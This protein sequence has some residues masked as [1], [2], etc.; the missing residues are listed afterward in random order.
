MKSNKLAF[1]ELAIDKLSTDKNSDEFDVLYRQKREERQEPK[2]ADQEENLDTDTE[3][4]RDDV[5]AAETESEEDPDEVVSTESFKEPHRVIQQTYLSVEESFID[6]VTHH[7]KNAARYVGSKTV[8]YGPV[9]LRNVY[10]GVKVAINSTLK[11]LK[12]LTAK[13]YKVY[14]QHINSYKNLHAKLDDIKKTIHEAIEND[15]EL[16]QDAVFSN[17]KALSAFTINGDAD[18]EKAISVLLKFNRDYATELKR[19][20]SAQI[21]TL[22]T[23]MESVTVEDN[24]TKINLA[25]TLPPFRLSGFS[26][27]KVRGYNSDNP[28]LSTFKYNQILPGNMLFL[29]YLPEHSLS[30]TDVITVC[31]ESNLFLGFDESSEVLEQLPIAEPKDLLRLINVAQSLCTV[32]QESITTY[33]DVANHRLTLVKDI[34]K[35]TRKLEEAKNTISIENSMANLISARLAFMDNTCMASA[36]SVHEVNIRVLT[37]LIAYFKEAINSFENK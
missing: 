23:V 34:E 30:R 10:E 5:D 19:N 26:L 14:K 16:K 17:Q 13:V 37:G 21:H 1:E 6:R 25:N 28:N 24:V 2:E 18:V 15:E 3:P 29:G 11:A 4:A 7:G 22:K 32:G 20:I 27:S 9:V 35:Y 12:A 8:E 36:V 31:Q 33:R